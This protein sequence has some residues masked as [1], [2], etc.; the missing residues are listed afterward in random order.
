LSARGISTPQEQS[1]LALGLPI[2]VRIA[3]M[4]N[5]AYQ[6]HQTGIAVAES[7]KTTLCG[8]ESMPAKS[9]SPARK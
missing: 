3:Q 1:S 5:R 7:M 6:L 4:H 9:L 2:L 8:E